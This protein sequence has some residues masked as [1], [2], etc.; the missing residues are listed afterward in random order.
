MLDR[1]TT[2]DASPTQAR[3]LPKPRW[4]FAFLGLAGLMGAAG[5]AVGAAG[6]HLEA[7]AGAAGGHGAQLAGTASSFLTIHAA[8]VTAGVGAALAS[9]RTPALLA[10]A[11]GLLVVGAV[12]FGGD[13]ALLGLLDLHPVPLA[14]PV[15]G[16]CLIA[17]WL[18]LS[19][20]AVAHG[21][22]RG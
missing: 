11:L 2:G 1:P 22:K 20:F 12:L 10:A 15:G 3:Q 21:L 13:L 7:A 5:V 6:A 19:V 8:A 9:R 14:A 16:L 18:C 4:P 17:G